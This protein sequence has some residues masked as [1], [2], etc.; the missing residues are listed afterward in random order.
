MEGVGVPSK[1]YE[2]HVRGQ[3]PADVLDELGGLCLS[4]EEPQ[5]VLRG[6]VRDQS[7]LHG[8]LFRLAN[9]GIDLVEVRLLDK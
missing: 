8:I 9:L 7:A 1:T 2:I 5:T 6:P 4:A 3:V